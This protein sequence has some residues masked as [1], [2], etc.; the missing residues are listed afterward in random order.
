MNDHIPLL[1][2]YKISILSYNKKRNFLQKNLLRIFVN[3]ATL[4]GHDLQKP[5]LFVFNSTT[6]KLV[7]TLELTGLLDKNLIF[8]TKIDKKQFPTWIFRLFLGS[9]HLKI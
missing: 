3:H 9:E 1:W 5:E 8:F 2:V 6:W 4:Q 7:E